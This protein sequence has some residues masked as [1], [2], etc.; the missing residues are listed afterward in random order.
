MRNIIR[1]K[2]GDMVLRDI[3]FIII[4][5][6]GIVALL[7][8]FVG[9]IG[10]TYED[11]TNMSI[12]YNQDDIG[13][14]QLN[15][16][17]DRWQEISISLT[18]GNIIERLWGTAE[19]AGEIILEIVKAPA[20]FSDLVSTILDDLGVQKDLTN[21]LSFILTA[22]LYILI[23]FVIITAFLPGGGKT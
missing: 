14:S 12:E 6:T 22:T 13:D 20:T 9:Q 2:R 8:I 10:T 17:G 11:Y 15:E 1:N 23:A 18:E 19:A 7:S 3:V 21:S 5:F 16:T 4:I